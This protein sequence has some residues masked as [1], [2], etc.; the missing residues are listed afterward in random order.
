MSALKKEKDEFRRELEQLRYEL[1]KR[2]K[3]VRRE[4]EK[5]N[6]VEGNEGKEAEPSANP[7]QASSEDASA[8]EESSG[9]KQAPEPDDQ[10]STTS[11]ADGE[12]ESEPSAQQE[13]ALRIL[14]DLI[15]LQETA[16]ASWLAPQSASRSEPSS[17]PQ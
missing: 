5:A 2:L 11:E 6:G 3:I 17:S 16:Q 15:E 7:P 10:A 14:A 13:E 1:G 8:G 4:A 12:E 9:A